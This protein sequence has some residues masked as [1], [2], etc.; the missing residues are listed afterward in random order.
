MRRNLFCIFFT[1]AIAAFACADSVYTGAY[2]LINSYPD[3]AAKG[4]ATGAACYGITAMG[5]NPAALGSIDNVE[6]AVLHNQWR[7][8]VTAEKMSAGKAFDFGN[9]GLELSYINM[10]SI[11]QLLADDYGNPVITNNSINL[12]A[13]GLSLVYGKKIKNFSMG[14]AARMFSENLG[15][16]DNYTGCA[17][18]G[19]I[20]DGFIAESMSAG[21]SLLNISP[22]NNEYY[23]PMDLKA[24]VIYKYMHGGGPVINLSAACD[25]LIKDNYLLG[26]VGFDY[27]MFETLIIRGGINMNQ[28]GE[29]NFS[30]GAG[31][32]L[33]GV[34]INYSY[35]PDPELG[36]A[37][38]L[39]IN[40]A[41]GKTSV[42]P[43]SEGKTI[44]E[45]GTFAGYLD[46]GNYYYEN[47]QYRQA[48]K[49]FEYINLMYWKDIE[50]K[51]EKDKSSFYQKIGIC[52]YNIKD[53]KRALQYF[54]RA[55]YF[56]KGNEILKHWIKSI[57]ENQ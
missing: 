41:F 20:Y 24:A 35:E 22:K 1:L 28:K 14:L 26:G 11:T 15:A 19:F 33:E 30:A 48:L 27:Y 13:W 21:L 42:P 17:D 32:K 2:M 16:V 34:T 57:K 44:S 25:Y 54:D 8:D 40:A 52:Y 51:S 38:K 9:I 12:N 56:D 4:D 3:F 55:L 43:E 45:K 53:N 7:Q 47:K 18:A 50:D 49:Y 31:I 37:H 39:S 29:M 23:T 36:D 46:S 6:F 5:A 10:G